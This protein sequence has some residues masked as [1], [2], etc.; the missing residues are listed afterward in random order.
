MGMRAPRDI[1]FHK[2]D[3]RET[4]TRHICT[5]IT[6]TVRHLQAWSTCCAM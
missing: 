4:S 5:L 2:V 3:Q 1:I 6:C